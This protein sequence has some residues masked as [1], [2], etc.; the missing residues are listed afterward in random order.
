M[1]EHRSAAPPARRNA[2]E[3]RSGGHSVAGRLNVTQ[4][5]STIG[6]K[7]VHRK[8]IKALGLG[9]IGRT[10]TVPDSPDVR[11][12]LAKVTHLVNV[13]PAPEESS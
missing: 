9:G 4:V 11:G 10:I 8:T 13:E 6:T 3:E 12:M 2:A 1:S 5:K 7:P